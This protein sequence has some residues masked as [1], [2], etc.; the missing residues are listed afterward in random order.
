MTL[1]D[2]AKK[3]NNF[4]DHSL[5][6]EVEGEDMS[7]KSLIF[8]NVQVTLTSGFEASYCSFSVLAA[9]SVYDE[10]EL[11]V[12]QDMSKFSL[13]KKVDIYVTY[14]SKENKF[15]IFSGY[16]TSEN[17]E[18]S[19]RDVK[20]DIE[21][22]DLK[23][24]MMNNLRSEQKKDIKRYSEAVTNLLKDYSSL[25]D[26]SD[27]DQTDEINV[28]IEQYNQ[29]DYDFIVSI[30]KKLNFLFYIINGRI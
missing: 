12:S 17:F 15:K 14:G 4:S 7:I 16:I 2:L 26:T 6:V 11:K 24:L 18:Y 30:A 21:A 29:S 19:G 23:S 27:I 10:D 25:Y 20:Y 22:M 8:Q 9:T 1:D 3:Y 28:P 5:V 13:G